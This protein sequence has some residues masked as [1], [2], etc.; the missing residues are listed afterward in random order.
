MELQDKVAIITGAGAGIGRGIVLELASRGAAIVLA[1]ID[2]D[3]AR[4]V[5]DEVR[6]LGG[7]SAVT[8]AD[9]ADQASADAMV[10]AAMDEFGQV[11]ILVNNAGV[12]GAPGWWERDQETTE[13][14]DAAF[15]I[16]V[17]GIV[18][19]TQSVEPHMTER[20]YGKIV[21]IA[22][23]A[24]RVGSGGFAHYSASKAAAINV[25]QA[26]AF[27]LA[28][29]GINVNCIC[30]GLLWTGLWEKIAARRKQQRPDEQELSPRD[31]F[32]RRLAETTPLAREQMP[33][34][35]GKAAAFLVS[36]RSRNITGQALN[37]SGGFRNN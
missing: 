24:G 37:V 6:A 11:D 27:K 25:S 4:R 7:R 16:N 28:P 29:L 5:S 31:V 20:K 23:V 34:D 14:W 26:W 1:E 17:F 33:E 12:G 15:S 3:A 9:V 13:D 10:K 22:S 32:R 8:E 35:I 18:H 36:E 30:P 2:V 21:N 19:A